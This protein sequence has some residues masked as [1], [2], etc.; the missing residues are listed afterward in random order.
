M[1][2]SDFDR[3]IEILEELGMNYEVGTSYDDVY[4]KNGKFINEK[5]CGKWIS[6]T[7]ELCFDLNGK[8]EDII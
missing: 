2:K 4:D 3:A 5:E 6:C 8:I 7:L 1:S